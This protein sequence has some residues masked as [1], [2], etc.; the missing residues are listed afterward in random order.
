MT[1]DVG[2]VGSDT[3]SCN[4]WLLR[5][6]GDNQKQFAATWS[7]SLTGVAS[8]SCAASRVFSLVVTLGAARSVK[9]HSTDSMTLIEESETDRR[10][11]ARP[12][13]WSCKNCSTLL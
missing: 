10:A 9:V 13:R 7:P 1:S 2:L 3:G 11:S 5:H 4:L 12:P 6:E 8:L